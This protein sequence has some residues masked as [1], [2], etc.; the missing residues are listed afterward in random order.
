MPNKKQAAT[1]A[2]SEQATKATRSTQSSGQSKP[3]T[4][5]QRLIDLLSSEKPVTVEMV[6]K[7]LDWQHHTV[8]AAISGL[9]KAGF[10]I[11]SVKPSAGGATYY[12]IVD[13]DYSAG[14]SA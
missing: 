10:A 2:K 3:K 11:D 1:S 14:E 6:S 12:H 4:K 9:R 5:K 7:T 8:R 13:M